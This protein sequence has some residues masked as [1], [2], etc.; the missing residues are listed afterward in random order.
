MAAK[1]GIVAGGG[2]LPARVVEACRAQGRELFV[3]AF[4]GQTEPAAVEGVE[5]AWVRLGRSR[6]ALEALRG[7]GVE[8]AP[9][10]QE[11]RGPRL[12]ALLHDERGDGPR[13]PLRELLDRASF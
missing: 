5:H 4:E 11:V 8:E 2:E 6:P 12:P 9:A 7:A 1:L 3:L 10:D 13:S